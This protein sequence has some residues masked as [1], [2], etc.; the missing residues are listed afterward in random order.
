MKF[1]IIL[2]G[3][4]FIHCSVVTAQEYEEEEYNEEDEFLNAYVVVVDTSDNYFNIRNLMF[5]V[6]QQLN[7]EID[8]L[9]R[10]YDVNKDLICLP[11]DHEDEIYAGDYF[12]RSYPS[13]GLSI[14]YL[15]IYNNNTSNKTFAL[16]SGIFEE[17]SEAKNLLSNL[18]NIY[19]KSFLIN[20]DLYIGSMH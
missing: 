20:T 9:E 18:K 11:D 2:I 7:M 17:E 10:S 5:D 13:D 6:S 14:E 1:L 12:P 19:K 15:I 4:L 3:V 8:T 16:I